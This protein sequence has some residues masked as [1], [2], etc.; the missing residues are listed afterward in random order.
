MP[1]YF[2][3]TMSS[4]TLKSKMYYRKQRQD[5]ASHDESGAFTQAAKQ[6]YATLNNVAIA[7]VVEGKFMSG[8]GVPTTPGAEE[9]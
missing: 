5:H 6:A 7:D 2:T 8:Q 4:G 3:Q 9:I 1:S